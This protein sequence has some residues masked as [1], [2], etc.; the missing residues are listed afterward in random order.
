MR[1]ATRIQASACPGRPGPCRRQGGG[2]DS[3]NRIKACAREIWV[4][5]SC[6]GRTSTDWACW[7]TLSNPNADAR[8][9]LTE[10]KQSKASEA[11]RVQLR[12]ERVGCSLRPSAEAS[13]SFEHNSEAAEPDPRTRSGN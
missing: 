3:R 7:I 11:Q 5:I 12:R 13:S 2:L 8:S 10:I 9:A 6:T 1:V 4:G